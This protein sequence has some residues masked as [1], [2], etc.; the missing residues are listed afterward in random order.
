M[1]HFTTGLVAIATALTL[2]LT[3]RAD[4]RPHSWEI[5]TVRPKQKQL[6]EV[7]TRT[8]PRLEVS[9]R[10]RNH[11]VK[12]PA[13]STERPSVVEIGPLRKNGMPSQGSGRQQR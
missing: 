4:T 11:R 5:D 10:E 7:R 12:R 2:S 13:I 1:I 3:L 9:S 6:G 8:E